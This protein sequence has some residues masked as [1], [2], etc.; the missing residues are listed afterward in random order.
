MV[1]HVVQVVAHEACGF[2]GL[3]L[4]QGKCCMLLRA[5]ESKGGV[6]TYLAFVANH[7][8]G[9]LLT[10]NDCFPSTLGLTCRPCS[11]MAA[12]PPVLQHLPCTA[13]T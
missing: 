4:L 2:L 10:L 5:A 13:P 3:S 6:Q 9:G 1:M 8:S 7:G 12:F 11:P